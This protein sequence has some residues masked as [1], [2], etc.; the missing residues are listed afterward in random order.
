MAVFLLSVAPFQLSCPASL[1]L[2]EKEPW[3][4]ETNLDLNIPRLQIYKEISEKTSSNTQI[5]ASRHHRLDYPALLFPRKMS[6]FQSYHF[7]RPTKSQ[8]PRCDLAGCWL[9]VWWNC[10]T[11]CMPYICPL[12]K[13]LLVKFLLE[14]FVLW[15]IT[16]RGSRTIIF[17]RVTPPV[18]H[19][20]LVQ[21]P[22]RTTWF[23][24]C[25]FIHTH[26]SSLGY[27]QEK[28]YVG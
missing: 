23:F 20:P 22:T 21:K 8:I 12:V 16:F 4:R 11:K 18:F 13:Y 28:F 5:A 2:T 14:P 24:A 9:S 19:W 26:S 10:L 1:S 15:V 6:S 3:V 7:Y 25:I 27:I 17:R